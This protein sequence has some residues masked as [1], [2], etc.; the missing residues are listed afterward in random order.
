MSIATGPSRFLVTWQL[1]IQA[2]LWE[3][4][5]HGP[6]LDGYS[7]SPNDV[8][9]THWWRSS[10]K[11]GSNASLTRKMN[12]SNFVPLMQLWILRRVRTASIVSMAGLLC[13]SQINWCLRHRFPCSGTI[14]QHLGRHILLGP[15]P[16]NTYA[17]AKAPRMPRILVVIAASSQTS[18][19][20][21]AIRRSFVSLPRQ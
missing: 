19:I 16:Y 6:M 20:P 17:R 15:V 5:P 21:S 11:S 1:Q 13:L 7:N 8:K 3:S 4:A 14:A 2:Y 12:R 18:A 10:R 9:G